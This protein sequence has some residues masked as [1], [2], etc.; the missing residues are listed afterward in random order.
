ML[1][2]TLITSAL[3]VCVPAFAQEDD[4]TQR[5]KLAKEMVDLR[6]ASEQLE[7]ALD[8]YINNYLLNLSAS[9]KETFR[10]VMLQIMNPKALEKTAVDAYAEIF[11]LKELEAMVAYY[12]LPE[13]RS[14][15]DKQKQLN[16]RMAPEIVRMLDQAM[17]RFRTETDLP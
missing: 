9:E 13:A 11:T 7:S 14:S 15:R 16:A 6:P 8:A 1:R 2:L 4:F 5:L 17:M 12:S 10:S 3:L